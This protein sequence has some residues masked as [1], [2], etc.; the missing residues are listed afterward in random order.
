[1]VYTPDDDDDLFDW[2]DDN[3]GHIARHG[4][5]WWEAE[6]ALADPRRF[7]LGRSVVSGEIRFSYAGRTDSGRLLVV[8]YTHRD[9]RIR[10]VTAREAN[11]SESGSYRGRV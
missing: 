4:V 6:E 5:E 8:V 7:G 11:R 9:G 1:M 10:V 3:A 2:D